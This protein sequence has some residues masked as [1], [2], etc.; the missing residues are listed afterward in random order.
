MIGLL[1]VILLAIVTTVRIAKIL[2]SRRALYKI[3]KQLNGPRP[4]LPLIGNALIFAGDTSLHFER[5]RSCINAYP[6]PMRLWLGPNLL[7]VFSDVNHVEKILSTTKMTHK[8]DLYDIMKYYVGNGLITNSGPQWKHDRRILLPLF[9]TNFLKTSFDS[10]QEHSVSFV[11]AFEKFV[12]K[13]YSDI[14]HEVHCLNFDIIGE[15]ICGVK[16]DTIN[17]SNLDVLHAMEDIYDNIFSQMVKPWIHSKIAFDLSRYKKERSKIM[18]TIRHMVMNTIE[19]SKERV[20]ADPEM[21]DGSDN[22]VPIIDQI[23]MLPD[24]QLNSDHKLLSDHIMT[25]FA[26]SEDTTT[27]TLC[28]TCMCFGMYPEYQK[29]AAQEVRRVFGDKPRAVTY[30]DLSELKYL[31]MCIKDCLRLATIAPIILRKCTE[32]FE[33]DKWTI[34]QG[35][36]V[37]LPIFEIHRDPA[38]WQVPLHFYPDHFLPENVAK[39]HPYAYLPFSMGPRG[40]IGKA[41]ALQ[42]LKIELANLLQHY[43]FECDGKFPDIRLR[44][45]IS[46]RPIDGYKVKVFKRIWD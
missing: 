43:Q 19:K 33:I 5:I 31:E 16:L 8:S 44:N 40:C 6:H 42:M 35:A 2:W 18:T 36:N 17:G 39:R 24:V 29:I 27:I 45:D 1:L 46:V 3:S 41:L 4:S 38:Q 32:D 11:R 10:M 14:H 22:F 12:G 25:L 23:H 9:N 20:K 26:A 37:L 13:G 30:E 21:L 28:T 15:I 7:L 34:P